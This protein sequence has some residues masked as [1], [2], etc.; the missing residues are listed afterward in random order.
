MTMSTNLQ[1]SYRLVSVIS[2]DKKKKLLLSFFSSS[3]KLY[4]FHVNDDERKSRR[5]SAAFLI[6]RVYPLFVLY[7]QR[8]E[9]RAHTHYQKLGRGNMNV[10]SDQSSSE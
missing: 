7:E 1:C 4:S 8:N 9:Q 10:E 3:N 5:E 2:S 6:V